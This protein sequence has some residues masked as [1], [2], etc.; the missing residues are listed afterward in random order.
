MGRTRS[1]GGVFRTVLLLTVGAVW[2]VAALTGTARADDNGAAATL[3]DFVHADEV[4]IQGEDG[5]ELTAGTS[6]LTLDG[7]ELQV[8][9]IDLYHGAVDGAAYTETD[10]SN[11]TLSGNPDAGKIGWILGH[12]FPNLSPEQ[13]AQSAGIDSLDEDTAAAGTQAAIWHFSDKVDAVPHD[14]AAARLT[15]WL[16][17]HAEDAGEPKPTL[18][19]SASTLAGNSNERIG[20][21]TVTTSADTIGLT[22]DDSPD[23]VRIVDGQGHPV[24]SAG[25]GD[26][27]YFSVPPG[28]ASGR[29]RLTATAVSPPTVGRAFKAV[30]GSSQTLIL[31]GSAPVSVTAEVS[32]NWAEGS[33][34]VIPAANA[35]EHCDKGGVLV[36]LQNSGDEPWSTTVAGQ[37]AVV[38]PG[39]SADVLVKVREGDAYDIEVT[40]PGGFSKRFQG[41]LKCTSSTFR[42]TPPAAAPGTSG[43]SGGGGLART[44]GGSA[45]VVMGLVGVAAALTGILLLVVHHRGFRTSRAGQSRKSRRH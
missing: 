45:P 2:G 17:S 10:W 36:T 31:G 43:S 19:L 22:L 25:N 9:C 42:P 26:Q 1:T 14:Q 27:L 33:H 37:E 12:S 32:V 35:E 21:V 8:Y 13:V 23:G 24:T 4:E 15:E 18:Q 28:A 16:T 30:D 11:S 39:G 38:K 6:S 41:A 29:A 20:P 44:G 3:G 5:Y 34:D 7:Q 40:G